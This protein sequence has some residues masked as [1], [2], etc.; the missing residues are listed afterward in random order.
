MNA[1]YLQGK[2]LTNAID[3]NARQDQIVDIEH[4]S[5]PQTDDVSD[6]R[7]RLR[8][9]RVELDMADGIKTD[10]VKLAVS[11]VVCHVTFF[12]LFHQVQLCNA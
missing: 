11:L 3:K 10:Q 2:P 5:S 12:R 6:V 1:I 9:A 4:R 7:V 8:A